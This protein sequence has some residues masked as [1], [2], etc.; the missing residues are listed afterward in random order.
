LA[1]PA[2]F[3]DVI[4]PRR[5]KPARDELVHR[6]LDNGPAP[7]GRALGAVGGGLGRQPERRRFLPARRLAGFGAVFLVVLVVSFVMLTI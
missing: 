2:R 3:G 7:L 6:R 4:K 5:R 1:T